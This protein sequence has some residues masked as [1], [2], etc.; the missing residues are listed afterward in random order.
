MGSI[1]L[2]LEGPMQSWDADSRFSRRGAGRFPT[3]SGILGMLMNAMGRLGEQRELLASLSQGRLDITA[4]RK[5]ALAEPL[6]CDFHMIGAG[7]SRNPRSWECYMVPRNAD[8]ILPASADGSTRN[9]GTILT[10]RYYI[11]DMAFAAALEIKDP[12][13]M[14]EADRCLRYP[15]YPMWLGRKC[16]LP[17]ADVYLGSYPSN[18]DALRV[19][20]ERARGFTKCFSVRELSGE[21]IRT[22]GAE[23]VRDVPISFGKAFEK[24]SRWIEIVR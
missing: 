21:D 18:E 11:Q 17:S 9:S 7:Y 22:A 1:L 5:D 8:G 16:C 19:G 12:S 23:L 4:Y 2:W 24:R 3:K 20:K 10:Y 15:V 13:I 14:E 6:L